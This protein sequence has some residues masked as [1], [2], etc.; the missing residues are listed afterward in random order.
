MLLNLPIIQR[1]LNVETLAQRRTIARLCPPGKAYCGELAWK[2]IWDR[3]L[4]SYCL[5]TVDHVRKI[6]D[7]K[8]R[9]N[10]GKYCFVN[11]TI[12]AW[13]Q[14]PVKALGGLI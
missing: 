5:C 6:K 1:T 3:L 12:K 4:R 9:T 8:Q 2:V 14:L 7:R 11:R 10:V 13:N